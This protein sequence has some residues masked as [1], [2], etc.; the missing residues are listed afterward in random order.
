[1]FFICDQLKLAHW[2]VTRVA[3]WHPD[4]ASRSCSRSGTAWLTTTTEYQGRLTRQNAIC[5]VKTTHRGTTAGR[6]QQRP[7]S[8]RV[9]ECSHV[10]GKPLLS[11]RPLHNTVNLGNLAQLPQPVPVRVKARP[12][13]TQY[14]NKGVNQANLLP[15]TGTVPGSRTVRHKQHHKCLKVGHLNPRS[16]KNKALSLNDFIE[17]QDLDILCITES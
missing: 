4:T 5:A 3:T 15:V 14:D 13:G 9:S 12:S 16:L 7:I 2:T 1:M 8:T 17:S 10:Y 6:D 11:A